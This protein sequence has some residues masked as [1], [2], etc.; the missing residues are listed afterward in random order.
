MRGLCLLAGGLAAVL[1]GSGCRHAPSAM[2]SDPLFVSKKPMLAIPSL[3]PPAQV[4]F[5]EPEAPAGPVEAIA[6]APRPAVPPAPVHVAARS[7]TPE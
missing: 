6:A 7:Q 5:Y 2:P 1:L 4:A 3:K